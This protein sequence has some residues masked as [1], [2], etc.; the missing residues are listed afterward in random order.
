MPELP[1]LAITAHSSS[2][3][4]FDTLADMLGDAVIDP[5]ARRARRRWL[6]H[7]N[8]PHTDALFHLRG[9]AAVHAPVSRFVVDLNRRRDRGGLNGA[10]KL[11]DFDGRPLYPTGFELA[12]AAAEERLARYWDPFHAAIARALRPA[13]GRPPLLF[14]LDGHAMTARG[15]RIGPDAGAVRPALSVITGGDTRGERVAGPP[16]VPAAL[17]RA[18]VAEMWRCFGDLIRSLPGVPD[19]IALNEPFA[20]GGIQERYSRPDPAAGRLRGTPGFSVEFNRALYLRPAD[21]GF[22]E[23]IPGRVADLNARLHACARALL[24]RF[25]ALAAE[26]EVGR[27]A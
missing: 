10:I 7:Q 2:Y 24:P 18:V 3:L 8:D 9:A 21:D 27:G 26:P 25:E 22:D 16:S 5:D 20:A 6:Y 13:P 17:A 12:P 1:I 15:P 19:E 4:P 14:F 11:T 23:P